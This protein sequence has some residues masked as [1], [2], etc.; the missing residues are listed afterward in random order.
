MQELSRRARA[1]WKR[2]FLSAALSRSRRVARSSLIAAV[3]LYQRT[4]GTALPNSCR[5][6]PTCSE[7]FVE[8]VQKF[9]A[10]KGTWLGIRRIL[11]CNPYCQGGH[12][13]VP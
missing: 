3:R 5:F 13:P 6:V 10:V 7:Y 4:V 9:G 11:R 12:D 8:A 2:R 1:E